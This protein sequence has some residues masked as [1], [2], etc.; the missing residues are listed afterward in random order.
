MSLLRIF[1]WKIVTVSQALEA[2]FGRFA[3][4]TFDGL[5]SATK[6]APTLAK[7]RAPATVFVV[8][9]GGPSLNKLI[10]LAKAGWEVGSLGHEL[11]DLTAQSYVQ[12]RRLVSRSFS[13]IAAK[14]GV[15]PRVFAYPFGAYDATTLSCVKSEGFEAA[16]TLRQGLN[17]DEGEAF[18]LKRMPLKASILPDLVILLRSILFKTA[19]QGQQVHH[20]PRESISAG[21]AL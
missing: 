11:V 15:A 16:V 6:C 13:L 21:A 19:Q 2:T 10:P 14:V 9:R 1:G 8:T 5:D 7:R 3:C 4:L 20:D 12:Q 17:G 18:Q